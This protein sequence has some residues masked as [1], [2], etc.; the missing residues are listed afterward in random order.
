[1]LSVKQ[2]KDKYFESICHTGHPLTCHAILP[3]ER[4]NDI[5]GKSPPGS[6]VYYLLIINVI[7]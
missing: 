6:C 7:A 2:Y 3:V 4:D 1:M 5:T